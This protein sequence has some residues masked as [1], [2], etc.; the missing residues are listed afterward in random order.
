VLR[1]SRSCTVSVS[2]SPVVERKSA[3]SL[4]LAGR[5]INADWH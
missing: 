1:K 4:S 2:V 3:F 5:L